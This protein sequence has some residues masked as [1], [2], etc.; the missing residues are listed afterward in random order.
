VPIEGCATH[1]NV[2][3]LVSDTQEASDSAAF[4]VCRVTNTGGFTI[5]Y[6]SN[7]N[8][9]RDLKNLVTAGK[10]SAASLKSSYPTLLWDATAP[11]DGV[12]GAKARGT[13]CNK[14]GA[15]YVWKTICEANASDDGVKMLKAQ[16]LATVLNV[17]RS[18][19]IG[20]EDLGDQV[21]YWNGEWK[22]V[23]AWLAFVDHNVDL[24]DKAMVGSYAS[25]FD[26]INNNAAATSEYTW[27]IL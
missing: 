2:V 14:V 17:A 22:T 18:A 26:A 4:E 24:T 27:T 20:D 3:T 7:N 21:V 8:G 16:F 5:G 9:Q 15:G 13:G 23:T 12:P 25:L 10:V 11:L 19:E 6:W 1:V